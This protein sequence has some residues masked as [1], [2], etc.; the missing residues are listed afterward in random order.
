MSQSLPAWRS[1]YPFESHFLEL[2]AH[3]MHY[4]D[5]GE[6][7]PVVMVHG[8]PSWSFMWRELI[9]ALR[10]SHRVLAPDHI[11]CGLS[12]K[13]ADS[14]YRYR[15]EQ[16]IADFSDFLEATVPSGPLTLILHDWGGPI[17]LGYAVRHPER[18]GRL[19]L[20]NTAAFSSPSGRPIHWTL[21]LCRRSR[22]LAFLIRR[23]NLFAQGAVWL[24]CRRAMPRAVRRG[25][26]APYDSWSNRIATLRFVQDIPLEPSH[27]SYS[28]LQSVEQGLGRLGSHP[29]LIC[30]GMRDFVFD[31]EFLNQW[32][33][34]F[35]Q[36]ETHEFAEG[37]HYLLED[38]PEEVIPPIIRFL[39]RVSVR[40]AAG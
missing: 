38:A 35:P 26:T 28:T 17:G 23:F 24:G 8:N 31:R 14:A 18:V 37:G 9:L 20:L 19:I 11:G 3:R 30:W 39:R 1:Y 25:Y 6:G 10:H 13:P 5:E 22:L 36:A 2:G 34:H 7:E 12:D 16:R 27:P 21:Q 33:K 32:R 40:G 15:L 29:L 4:L